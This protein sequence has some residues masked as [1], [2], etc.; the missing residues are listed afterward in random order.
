MH[1]TASGK[2][3]PLL[4]RATDGHGAAVFLPAG[5]NQ[6]TLPYYHKTRHDSRE[7]K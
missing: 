6:P 5:V 7:S 2:G 1:G 3:V 4:A